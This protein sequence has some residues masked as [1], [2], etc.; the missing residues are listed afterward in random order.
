MGLNITRGVILSALAGVLVAGAAGC[1]HH[2]KKKAE[3]DVKGAAQPTAVQVG[4]ELKVGD[5]VTVTSAPVPVTQVLASP[6]KYAG[7][8]MLISGTIEKVCVKKGCWVTL[9]DGAAESLYVKFTCSA[10]GGRIVPME[11]AGKKAVVQGV[12][13]VDMISEADARHM[14][15]DAGKSKEEIAKIVGPQKE[16]SVSSPA[17]VITMK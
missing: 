7:K 8:P 10:E 16:I 4:N 2:D 17:V 15:E 6:E 1:S 3:H 9:R 13:K 11:A 5:P 12:V 14:A